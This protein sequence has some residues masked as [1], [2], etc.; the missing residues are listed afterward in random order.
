MSQPLNSYNV[1]SHSARI[2]VAS[3]V[4]ALEIW[5]LACIL[6]VFGALAEY[7]FILRQ[8][9]R[10]S[11]KCREEADSSPAGTPNAHQQI[12]AAAAAAAAGSNHGSR[13]LSR[14]QSPSGRR[15]LTAAAQGGIAFKLNGGMDAA[16][17]AAALSAAQSGE[18]LIHL[19]KLER[20]FH[21]SHQ[22]CLDHH[23]QQQHHHHH[24]Q[25][26]LQTLPTSSS[27]SA[28]VAQ[29]SN[30]AGN[31]GGD[32]AAVAAR[33]DE[34]LIPTSPRLIAS[35]PIEVSPRPDKKSMRVC[36]KKS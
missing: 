28:A 16:A 21:S 36:S 1:V 7:A 35:S 25:L 26:P 31:A 4:T 30:G 32:E 29:Q 11:R 14:L 12:R 10:L 18:D 6:L 13:P 34:R 33:P 22:V 15:A 9:I 24:Q 19:Q 17:A 5:L 3:Q 27:A 8:V 20:Q 2:P 23:Q